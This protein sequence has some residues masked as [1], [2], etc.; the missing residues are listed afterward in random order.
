MDGKIEAPLHA[1]AGSA[2]AGGLFIPFAFPGVPSVGCAF[3]TAHAGSVSMTVD[4]GDTAIAPANRQRLLALLGVSR[5]AELMQVHGD[6]FIV[7]A[8]PTPID[9]P[10]ERRADGHGTREKGLALLI[11]TA[12]CQPILFAAA[13]GSAV[14]ALHA[15]WRG[16]AMNY[17]ASGL[18][19][20]CKAYGLEPSSVLAVRGPSLG[21]AAAEFVNF[22]REWPPQFRP[23]FDEQRRT[24]D[25]WR[26]TR[27]QLVGAGM[28]P[29]RIF[30]LDLCTRS[31]PEMFFSYRLGHTGRQAALIWIKE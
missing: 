1:S 12:D 8:V 14:A 15:G 25:L 11:K 26:L 13:D 30:G 19:R 22:E 2:E 18:E 4:A 9:L 5:W 27:E 21:P 16:N 23:W 7:D 20:F 29:E 17:P 28:A 6:A 31:L 24:M 10:P 3:S